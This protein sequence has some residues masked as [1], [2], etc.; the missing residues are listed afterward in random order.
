MRAGG[1]LGG[2]GYHR[3]GQ[4]LGTADQEVHERVVEFTRKLMP[5]HEERIRLHDGP[6]P[7]FHTHG[8]EQDFEKLFARRVELP[9]GGC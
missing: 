9:S 2:L 6:R 1:L 3:T 4:F 7:L 8:V 5:E